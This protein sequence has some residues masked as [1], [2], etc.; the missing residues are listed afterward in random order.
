M[1]DH[2]TEDTMIRDSRSSTIIL[3]SDALKILRKSYSEALY[4]INTS[5]GQITLR[6]EENW[7]IH[8]KIFPCNEFIYITAWNP[9]SEPL[10]EPENRKNNFLL[11]SELKKTASFILEGC[12]ESESGEW[13]EESFFAA[14]VSLETGKILQKQFGQNAFLYGRKGEKIKL[15]F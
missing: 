2:P 3:D 4:R 14:D 9:G 11:L 10:P 15:I 1:Q 8:E 12:S 13:K 6:T 5:A 7:D